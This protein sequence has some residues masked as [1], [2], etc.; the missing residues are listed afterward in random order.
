MSLSPASRFTPAALLVPLAVSA[1]FIA[2]RVSV[3]EVS[4]TADSVRVR[5][6]VKAHLL[7]GST[8]VY[9]DGVIVAA[10]RLTGAGT[11][12]DLALANPTSVDEL[13]LDSLVGIESFRTSVDAGATVG[14]STLATVG[15]AG[16]TVAIACAIDPKCFGSCPT[17]YSDSAGTPVL[18]AEEIGR[19]SCRERV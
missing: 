16:L 14:L 7:D 2:H 5:T 17:Y 19:A 12:Y 11:R 18:E 9:R 8:V 10:G 3:E 4:R 15:V 1:C 13:S 6:P